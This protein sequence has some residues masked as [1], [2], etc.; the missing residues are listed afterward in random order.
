MFQSLIN[1]LLGC[2]HQRTTFPITPSRKAASNSISAPRRS[3]TYVTCLDCGQEFD[4]DWK[5]MRIGQPVM[6]HV[7]TVTTQPSLNH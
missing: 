7:S 5:A 3:G 4:Y 2:S 6:G 1:M